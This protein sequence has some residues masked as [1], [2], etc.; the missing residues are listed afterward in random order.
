MECRTRSITYEAPIF[1]DVI[2]TQ[3]SNPPIEHKHIKIG[4]IPVMLR[5]CVC[6]LNGITEAEMA[7]KQV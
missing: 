3:S 2:I 1:V 5:S 4:T 7:A 6:V